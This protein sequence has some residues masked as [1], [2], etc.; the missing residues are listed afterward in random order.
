MAIDDNAEKRP[1]SV[2]TGE[3]I[4]IRFFVRRR[5]LKWSIRVYEKLISCMVVAWWAIFEVGYRIKN[6]L[7]DIA[8]TLPTMA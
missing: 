2:P 6:R 4:H 3:I 8:T 7:T 5:I 1:E